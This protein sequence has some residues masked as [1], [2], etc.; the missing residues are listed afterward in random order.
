M[1]ALG[2]ILLYLFNSSSHPAYTLVISG[3]PTESSGDTLGGSASVQTPAV[4]V[5]AS[6]P[7]SVK[8]TVANSTK[9]GSALTGSQQETKHAVFYSILKEQALNNQIVLTV[10]T[11]LFKVRLDG[12]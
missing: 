4:G 12:F 11:S 8:S 2:F 10:A 6:A 7:S 3:A 5:D 9:S 1:T